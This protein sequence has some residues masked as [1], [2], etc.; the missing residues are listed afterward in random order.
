MQFTVNVCNYKALCSLVQ[1]CP[2][3]CLYC[4]QVQ[5]IFYI[6]VTEQV[7]CIVKYVL[8]L[9]YMFIVQFIQW[10]TLGTKFRWWFNHFLLFIFILFGQTTVPNSYWKTYYWFYHWFKNNVGIV[11]S[12]FRL[13]NTRRKWRPWRHFFFINMMIINRAP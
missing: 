11:L 13:L 5:L 2:W 6:I 12:T 3:I 8:C 9:F 1:T 7:V 4:L 10:R